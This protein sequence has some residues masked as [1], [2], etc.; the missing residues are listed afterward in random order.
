MILAG[1][2]GRLAVP[3]PGAEDV[4]MR[5]TRYKPRGFLAQVK[6]AALSQPKLAGR[7]RTLPA[8]I[9]SYIAPKDMSTRKRAIAIFALSAVMFCANDLRCAFASE[10]TPTATDAL[11]ANALRDSASLYLREAAGG[12]IRWQPWNEATFTLARTL[13]RPMLIDIG[14]VWCHWCHV[15]DQTTYADA[16]VAAMINDYYVP[17]KVDTDERPDIDGYY[18]AAAQNFSA[19]G[20][21]LTCFATPDGAPL[22]IAGYL[23]PD[24]RE[25][26][27]MLW[28]L[29]RIRDAYGQ[30]PKLDQ[31]AHEIAAKVNS[32]ENGIG[33]KPSSFDEV[34]SAILSGTRLAFEADAQGH[35]EGASFYDFPAIQMM[36]AHGFYGHP[37]F[38]Q[39][40]VAR[41]K[42]ISSGGVFDHLAGGFHRYSVDAKWRVP[43]FEKMA[44]DQAMALKS[45]AQ[46]YEATHDEDFARVAKSI[47]AY[48]NC[49]MFDAA[50]H[51][52]YSHQDAD[53][54][55]G[56]DGSYYTWTED[57]LRHL[58]KGRELQVVLLHFGINDDPGRAPDGRIVLRY[59]MSPDDIARKLRLTVNEVRAALD[60]A[61]KQMRAS[62]EKRRAPQVDKTVL[63]DRNALMAS[64]Y[65][66]ASEA[67]GDEELRR[68]ALDDLDFLYANS[69][70]ADGTFYH[71]LD[72]GK[73]SV[74]GLAADQVYMMN[75]LLDAY[76]ASGDRKYLDRAMTLGAFVFEA[77]RDPAT[78][79]LRSRAPATAGTVLT[80]A[81]PLVQV[82]YD[83]P[84]PAIQATAAEAFQTLAVLTS[85]AGYAEKSEQLLRPAS[86]RIG[87]FAGPNNGELGLVLEQSSNGGTV[88]AIA[89]PDRDSRTMQLWHSALATYRPGKIVM[90]LS[91]RNGASQLP[92]AMKAMYEAAAHHEAPLAFVC[93]G[94]ACAT[95]SSS[96]NALAKTIRE[97]NVSRN[98]AGNLATR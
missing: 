62:R 75:A 51:T 7:I 26:R 86:T 88:V 93:A 43:H 49:T 47:I 28:V 78:G 12:A 19:G 46:A 65:I 72:H 90:R 5:G 39:A 17:V 13:K 15:M 77:F 29:E 97:F 56:D 79:M 14:A 44:Y 37:E 31:F 4:F 48:V 94:T 60:H 66:I 21:P 83:D 23:P 25:H 11:P 96:S 61:E 59:A 38:T 84:A 57:E 82:F 30:D 32:G 34:R 10:Q 9:L 1:P 63:I 18:Q 53:S 3:R 98:G 8:M 35:S 81:A 54:F 73:P 22:L 55:A 64:A 68:I 92:E 80:Q 76:Q 41:L 16:K 42:T 95:P 58:L 87:P 50:S 27:G 74:A 33:A 45:Y 89:G 24:A 20:W 71:V 91:A 6:I 85:D 36:L 40:A 70:A 69:R 2:R 52:F 67:L